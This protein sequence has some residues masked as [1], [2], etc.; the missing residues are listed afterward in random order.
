MERITIESQRFGRIEAEESELI[1]FDGL[2]GFP[3]ARRFVLRRHFSESPFAWLVCADAPEL[4]FV[5]TNPWQFFPGY[6]PDLRVPELGWLGSGGAR[7]LDV[8][9]I[10]TVR[11]AE[12][13]LNLA[14]PLVVNPA[15]RR[16][17]Q[18]ILE[19]G[20]EPMRALVRPPEPQTAEGPGAMEEE[21]R[22]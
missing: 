6:S 15:T 20:D 21:K 11:G 10:A 1:H 3:E 8:L 19:G 13:T 18:A 5:V 4:G 7:E 9:V 16:A 12:V 14:A 17:A 22:G 2:P